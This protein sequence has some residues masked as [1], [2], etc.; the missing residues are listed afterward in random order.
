MAVGHAHEDAVGRDLGAQLGDPLD[1]GGNGVGTV[2]LQ[3][4]GDEDHMTLTA[5]NDQGGGVQRVKD[6]LCHTQVHLT[7]QRN[8]LVE[9][10]LTL[11]PTNFNSTHNITLLFILR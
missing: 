5:V 7:E 10:G 11:A 8:T 4:A 1:G 2:C 3:V 9:G 6:A